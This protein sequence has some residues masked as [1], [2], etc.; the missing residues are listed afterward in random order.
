MGWAAPVVVIRVL[1]F[2]ILL[3]RRHCGDSRSVSCFMMM[4]AIVRK[5]SVMA[6]MILFCTEEIARS[7]AVVDEVRMSSDLCQTIAA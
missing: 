7:C 4:I 1:V 3:V 6:L 5:H 2:R